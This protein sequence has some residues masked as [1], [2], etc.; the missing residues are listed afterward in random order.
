MEYERLGY[1]PDAM[2]N[3]LALLGWSPGG[4]REGMTIAEMIEL[5]DTDG[6]LKKAAVFDPQKL[7]W[8]NG[9]HLARLPIAELAE[10]SMY[11]P[12]IELQ[13]LLVEAL[14]MSPVVANI[15]SAGS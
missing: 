3:F 10:R 13:H 14:G 15:I 9:Q 8:M 12:N 2:V 6:L 4:D 11:D 1:L 7:L 5:F